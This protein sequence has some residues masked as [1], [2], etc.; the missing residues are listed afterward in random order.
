MGKV[1][2]IEDDAVSNVQNLLNELDEL[3]K[4]GVNIIRIREIE[5]KLQQMKPSLE[6][7]LGSKRLEDGLQFNSY[8][9]IDDPNFIQKLLTKK[10]F[11]RSRYDHMDLETSYEQVV[12][13]KCGDDGGSSFRLTQNQVFLKSFLNPATHYNSLLLFHGVGVGKTCS[14]LTIAEQFRNTYNKRTLVLSPK[15]LKENF[16]RQA[17]DVDKYKLDKTGMNQC[18]ASK[19]IDAIPNSSSQSTSAIEKKIK[20]MIKSNYEFKSFEK[21]ANHIKEIV[22]NIRKN[23]PR[24]A[25]AKAKIIAEIRKHYSDRMIIVDEVHNTRDIEKDT[26]NDDDDDETEDSLLNFFDDGKKGK[27]VPPLL[28]KMLRFSEN[29][30]LLL[31]TATPMFDSATEIVW[32]LNYLMANEK[33][34]LLRKSEIFQNNKLT[35]AGREVI[36]KISQQMVSYMRGENPYSFP[37]RMY[38]LKGTDKTLTILP[39]VTSRMAPSQSRV[40]EEVIKATQNMTTNIQVS[41][42]VFPTM[43]KADS[44]YGEEGFNNCFVKTDASTTSY[45]YNS[46]ILVKYGEFLNINNS[47]TKYSFENFSAKMA[48]IINYILSSEGI[49]FVYSS[50]KYAGIVP[51][52][53]ALEHAGFARYENAPL[54]SKKGTSKPFL[55]NGKQATYSLLTADKTFTPDFHNDIKGIRSAENMNGEV[56]KVVLG[57]SVSSEGLDLKRIREVHFIEPWFHLN[58]MEQVIGRAI[59]TCSHVELPPELRNVTIYHH[60]AVPKTYDGTED[61]IDLHNYRLAENKQPLMREVENVIIDNSLDCNL[62][63][64]VLFYDPDLVNV[65]VKMRTSQGE[66]V[67]VRLGDKQEG[68]VKFGKVTCTPRVKKEILG[69]DTSSYTQTFYKDDVPTYIIALTSLFRDYVSSYTFKQIEEHVQKHIKDYDSAILRF[70]LQQCLDKK[71]LLPSVGDGRT[72]HVVHN[73]HLVYYGNKYI[74]SPQDYPTTYISSQERAD[75]GKT[76]S[77]R[78]MLQENTAKTKRGKMDIIETIKTKYQEFTK[79]HIGN[80]KEIEEFFKYSIHDAVADRLLHNE[81]I[82]INTEFLKS[83]EPLIANIRDSLFSSGVLM[84]VKIK[85]TSKVFLRSPFHLQN[86]FTVED[87]GAQEAVQ[88]DKTDRY[89]P[90]FEKSDVLN[91]IID[92]VERVQHYIDDDEIDKTVNGSNKQPLLGFMIPDTKVNK[93]FFK[94]LPGSVNTKG[95]VCFQ[96]AD[97]NLKTLRKFIKDLNNGKDDQTK[98]VNTLVEEMKKVELCGLYE[99]TLRQNA[100]TRFC[101][102]LSYMIYKE[103]RAKLAK[104]KN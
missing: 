21:F 56:V 14:A 90:A 55:I 63:K 61:S 11:S 36:G 54:L 91:D 97:Y 39:V 41:N 3:E 83:K 75:I 51:L 13:D 20:S 26:S 12:T 42:I 37:Y 45:Q 30:K 15:N 86:L 17:F 19:Y 38:P 25:F 74:L 1:R 78:L 53:M 65:K 58:R 100:P 48:S 35:K 22:N 71:N 62:N 29:V 101:R 46:D 73:A 2:V 81:L 77:N 59:R 67:N 95:S 94:L 8:P 102:P 47:K 16:I 40:Y 69:K 44:A 76:K 87:N 82:E 31:M 7:E 68:H 93:V 70:T 23:E 99:L 84:E 72:G 66:E 103:M 9:D 57:T 32:L 28:L 85:T 33:R 27:L 80:S 18:I 6:K 98:K 50:Y 89:N 88:H 34:K 104:V 92:L 24:E 43:S 10:E 5:D 64:K 52:A 4:N 49:V 60:V 96:T 79:D